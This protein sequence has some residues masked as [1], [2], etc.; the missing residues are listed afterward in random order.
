[1]EEPDK[2]AICIFVDADAC[3]VKAEVYRVAERYGLKVFVVANSFMNVPRSEMIERVIVNEGPDAADHWIAERAGPSDIVITADIPLA[4]RCVKKGASVIGPT[5]KPFDDNSIGMA[6]A[7]RDL[8]TDMRSAG[9][10][11]R[12]PAR[13][14]RQ[15]ISR[16]LSALDLAVTKLK[17][18]LNPSP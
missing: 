11:T 12:G 4:A 1:M 10:T 17:R 6:V 9:A 5:G 7:T 18:K 14:S 15:D 8:M 16:F 3:P 13:L 2:P